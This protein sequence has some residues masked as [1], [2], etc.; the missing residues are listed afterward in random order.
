M[1][2]SNK[3]CPFCKEEVKVDAV[4]C[5]HCSSALHKEK[6]PYSGICPYC[7]ESIKKDAI[8]CKHCKSNLAQDCSCNSNSNI[9]A[10]S[11]T[12]ALAPIFRIPEN[13]SAENIRHN[14]PEIDLD[15]LRGCQY[16]WKPNCVL[17]P[18]VNP[19]DGSMTTRIRCYGYKR[20]KVC[21]P[22][23]P[24]SFKPV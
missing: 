8:K 17:E 18:D 11:S 14:I 10:M 24:I 23:I 20:V 13:L 6:E 9:Q 4:K 15:L 16:V 22:D 12:Q 7:K 2:N 3:N 19:V 1:K 5:K 21:P